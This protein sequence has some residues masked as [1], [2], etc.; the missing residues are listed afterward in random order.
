MLVDVSVKQP[1]RLFEYIARRLV[2]S[3]GV[4]EIMTKVLMRLG[5]DEIVKHRVTLEMLDHLIKSS[6]D[7]ALP[8]NL[9]N[10]LQRYSL[11]PSLSE[12]SMVCDI[13][14]RVD[15]LLVGCL[16]KNDGEILMFKSDLL[17]D[18]LLGSDQTNLGMAAFLC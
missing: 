18:S 15:S 5:F 14:D 7:P 3:E 1:D 8:Q 12:L 6:T 9:L 17:L 2:G 10:K 4:D 13:A 16:Y 11:K